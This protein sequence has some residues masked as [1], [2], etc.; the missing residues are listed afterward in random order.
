[1]EALHVPNEQQK[2]NGVLESVVN[3]ATKARH[4]INIIVVETCSMR[5]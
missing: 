3:S 2:R 5:V 4:F 1:M